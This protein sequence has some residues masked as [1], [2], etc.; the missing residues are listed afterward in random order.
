VPVSTRSSLVEDV[1]EG[2]VNR[3]IDAP[4]GGEQ[5]LPKTA[6]LSEQYGVSRTVVREAI[7]R[8]ESQGLV[9]VRH[10]VGLRVVQRLHKPVMTS[11]SVLLPDMADRLRQATD[12]RFLLEVEVA[13]LA[14]DRM[15][16]AGMDALRAE[17]RRL[18]DPGITVEDAVE[19]DTRFHRILAEHCGNDVLTLMLES[20]VELCRESRKLTISRTGVERAYDGHR[21]LLEAI[22]GQD[23]DGAVEAM[24]RHLEYT[25]EDLTLQLEDMQGE[26]NHD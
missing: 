2:L 19:A 26:Q 22:A 16:P 1:Y 6:E 18:A 17:Q 7:S 24:R 21:M 8:L 11:L 12:V 9:E 15:T 5:W 4:E 14:A 20:I 10:G 13:R 25:R 23:A 3:I